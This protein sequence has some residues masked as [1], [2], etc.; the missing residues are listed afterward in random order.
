MSSE[1]MQ[2]S[3]EEWEKVELE[4]RLAEQERWVWLTLS[5]ASIHVCVC[6]ISLRADCSPMLWSTTSSRQ[7]NWRL[8]FGKDILKRCDIYQC[9]N[10]QLLPLRVPPSLPPSPSVSIGVPTGNYEQQIAGQI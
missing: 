10:D 5:G 2:V 3:R 6:I 1:C 4:E 7:I 9:Q 8:Q